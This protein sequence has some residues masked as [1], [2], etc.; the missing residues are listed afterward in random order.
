MS[1][2]PRAGVLFGA[3]ALVM[4]LGC[5]N[6]NLGLGYVLTFLMSALAVVSDV[7]HFPQPG[8]VATKPRPPRSRCLPEIKRYS[9]LLSDP[10]TVVTLHRARSSQ[11]GSVLSWTLQSAKLTV[12]EVRIPAER[13]GRLL[14]RAILRVYDVSWAVPPGPT[15]NWICIAWSIRV[16]SRANS[17]H[18]G[19][20][21]RGYHRAGERSRAG[22]LLRSAAVPAWRTRCAH[23]A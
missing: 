3:T 20:M 5:I 8:S 15:L 6:Y 4:L 23:V 21:R 16:R 7:A 9:L 11:P 19:A 17:T 2:R 14:A 1:F 12:E 18:A 10:G 13:R 22:R